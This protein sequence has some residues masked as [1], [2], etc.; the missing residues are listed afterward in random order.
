MFDKDCGRGRN[1]RF[2]TVVACKGVNVKVLAAPD[3]WRGNRENRYIPFRVT[4]GDRSASFL[5]LH[6]D[7]ADGLG[8][9]LDHLASWNE[10][11]SPRV[12]LFGDFNS[13]GEGR[14]AIEGFVDAH[15]EGETRIEHHSPDTV[16]YRGV[17]VSVEGVTAECA[18]NFSDHFLLTCTVKL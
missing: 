13:N 3:A 2:K 18:C 14:K 6:A 9:V 16:M 17:S 11:A 4:M 12:V 1:S 15:P 7:G 8:D 10:A 5:A